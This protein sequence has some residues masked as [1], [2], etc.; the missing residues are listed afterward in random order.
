M[1]QSI[2]QTKYCETQHIFF[3]CGCNIVICIRSNL[4][5]QVAHKKD[6]PQGSKRNQNNH[7]EA[8]TGP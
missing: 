1:I 8:L 3:V 7:K 5:I 2:I 6:N 4:Y